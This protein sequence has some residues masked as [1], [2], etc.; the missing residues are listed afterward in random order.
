MWLAPE[1]VHASAQNCSIAV[2]ME[3]VCQLHE[4][5]GGMG[6]CKE[7][8]HFVSAEFEALADKAYGELNCPQITLNGA[9]DVFIAVCDHLRDFQ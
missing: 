9:W 3:T 5:Y 1:S 7:S 2:D 4:D 8:F 6:A